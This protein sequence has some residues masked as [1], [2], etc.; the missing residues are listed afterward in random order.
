M[1]HLILLMP[2]IGLVVF[3]IWPLAIAIPVYLVILIVSAFIYTVAL[4][5]MRKPT[6]TGSNA[7]I[8]KSVDVIDMDHHKGHVRIEGEIWDARSDDSLQKGDEA[9]VIAVN[10]LTLKITKTHRI[11]SSK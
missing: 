6:M 4:R 7:L 3:W 1:C 11:D 10:D 2:L 8:G 9:R 5:A